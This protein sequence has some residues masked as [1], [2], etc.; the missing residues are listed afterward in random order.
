MALQGKTLTIT[1]QRNGRLSFHITYCARDTYRTTQR[2]HY[3]LVLLVRTGSGVLKCDFQQ[4]AFDAPCMMFLSP[5][6][7]FSITA[8]GSFKALSVGFHSD[9]FCIY[10][11]PKEVVC[12]DVLF[13]NLYDPP[14]LRLSQ[15][16][17]SSFDSLILQM[18]EEMQE[19]GFA[20]HEFLVASLKLLII[21][22][23]RLR[24]S[25]KDA[26]TAR[27]QPAQD[28]M[29]VHRFRD[30]LETNFR[31]MHAPAGYAD[32]LG[33]SQRT[34]LNITKKYHRSTVSQLIRER[35]M[36]EAK[37]E[38]YLTTKTV[39]EIAWDLGYEDE[40][41]FSRSF[42]NHVGISPQ[43]YRDTITYAHAV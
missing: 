24:I 20:H 22:A 5:Y 32:M 42:K 1:D 38:L 21:S 43:V 41:Y 33:I 18:S 25:Q 15:P 35:I 14:V 39:K 40:Y 28:L 36:I 6:Q 8:N 23:S 29:L 26:E 9:F 30:A 2:L 4:H 17:L 13:N 10:K 27:A 37:R 11:L 31:T 12:N 7:P 19:P 34:L 16:E 3:Y